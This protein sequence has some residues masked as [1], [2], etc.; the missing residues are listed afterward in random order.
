MDWLNLHHLHYFW[1]V[2]RKGGVRKAVQERRVKHPAV[3]AITEHA[4]TQLFV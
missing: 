1:A 3:V 2:A 4:Y